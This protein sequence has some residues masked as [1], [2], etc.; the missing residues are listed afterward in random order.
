MKK[1]HIKRLSLLA[2]FTGALC[3][4][5]A[6][7]LGDGEKVDAAS[8]TG[9][10]VYDFYIS[11]VGV[12]TVKD[13]YGDG[14]RFHTLMSDEMY[15]S[16]GS[17]YETG[18]I[19]LPELLYDGYLSVEMSNVAKVN[20]TNIWYDSETDGYMQS[21]AYIYGI[22]ES[23]FGAKLI[24]VSYIK[25]SDGDYIYSAESP[26]VS[27][28]DV[29]ISAMEKDESLTGALSGYKVEEV[30]VNYVYGE[31]TTTKTYAYN[32]V[33]YPPMEADKDGF[34]TV[35]KTKTGKVWDF[36]KY[37]ATGNMTLT[38]HYTSQTPS[39]K[40]ATEC[41][42]GNGTV[43]AETAPEGYEKLHS[44]EFTTADTMGL[45]ANT[46]ITNYSVLKFKAKATTTVYLGANGGKYAAVTADWREF[47]VTNN[48]DGTFTVTV[49]GHGDTYTATASKVSE[50]FLWTMW[51]KEAGTLYVTEVRGEAKA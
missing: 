18:T 44:V 45:F 36:E 21:T 20:T 5:S 49:D 46:D 7:A 29:A 31:T 12:R 40:T 34:D 26:S 14:I 17:G 38:A 13:E 19:F 10:S 50:V 16:L 43:V 24:A 1:K 33:L 2:F 27:M 8:I 3:V 37:T 51:A 48:N 23:Y 28:A 30:T 25:T 4:G 41:A 9:A 47:I 15:A 42:F 39:E 35:W 11:G 6:F 32:D 22:P